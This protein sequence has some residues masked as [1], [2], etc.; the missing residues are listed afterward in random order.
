MSSVGPE[1]RGVAAPDTQ[2]KLGNRGWRLRHSAW[3][4]APIFGL[5]FVTWVGFAY[6]GI[7]ARRR[8]WWLSAIVYGAVVV[9]VFAFSGSPDDPGTT[10]SEWVGGAIIAAWAAGIAHALL[11]NKSWLRWR[12]AH[13]TPWYAEP[14]QAPPPWQG[15]PRPHPDY[16]SPP[17]SGTGVDETHFYG[18]GPAAQHQRGTA[19]AP[20]P[21]SEGALDVNAATAEQLAALPGFDTERASRAL[22]ERHARRGFGSVEEFAQAAG[23]APHEF[24]RVQNMV[25]CSRSNDAAKRPPG[26]T[27]SGRV[28]DV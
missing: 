5:G 21:S 23:L 14:S 24:V 2:R 13:S 12:A 28:L 19:A 27:G 11:V 1:Q 10:S 3:M 4:L 25:T 18:T 20:A 9:I 22:M 15:A 16:T 6:I 26:S 7:K 17:G 8:D